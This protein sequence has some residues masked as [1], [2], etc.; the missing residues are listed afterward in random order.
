MQLDNRKCFVFVQSYFRG[1]VRSS[2]VILSTAAALLIASTIVH[3]SAHAGQFLSSQ[4]PKK[5]IAIFDFGEEHAH[6][7]DSVYDTV[8]PLI[9]AALPRGKANINYRAPAKCIPGSLRAVLAKVSARYGPITVNS[10]YRAPSKN[11]KVGGRGKSM[12]LSCR[13]VDF[14]VHGSTRGLMQFLTSQKGVG[15]YNRYP[16]GFYHIDNGPRRTW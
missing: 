5:Q 14:R 2:S 13:A 9:L 1:F 12:H 7:A 11:R 10:T 3:Q 6:L 15:G 8:N 16:S 4:S